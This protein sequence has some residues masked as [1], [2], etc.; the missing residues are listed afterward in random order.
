MAKN[1][2]I[3]NSTFWNAPNEKN[4]DAKSQRADARKSSGGKAVG[5]TPYAFELPEVKHCDIRG[6]A[7]LSRIVGLITLLDPEHKY[8]RPVSTH[9]EPDD[10]RAMFATLHLCG[11]QSAV[12]KEI[13]ALFS[14]IH[15]N[16]GGVI[17]N[18]YRLPK[19]LSL[20]SW[21][22][23]FFVRFSHAC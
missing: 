20:S 6:N 17:L 14:P 3:R 7:Y 13:D 5:D 22:K 21:L 8:L 16:S 18:L 10:K 12:F 9:T 2:H 15:P 19:G 1:W 23:S 4:R 11:G